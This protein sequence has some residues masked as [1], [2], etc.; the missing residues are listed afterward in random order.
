MFEKAKHPNWDEDVKATTSDRT[1]A[2]GSNDL[3]CVLIKERKMTTRKMRR[4]NPRDQIMYGYY[5]YGRFIGATIRK[6]EAI[7]EAEKWTGKPWDEIKEYIEVHK[8]LVS[9][10]KNL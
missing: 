8:I 6:N 2:S 3:L 1:S 10:I 5:N 4:E 9:K 7:K